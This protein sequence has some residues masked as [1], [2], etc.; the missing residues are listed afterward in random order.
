MLI[1]LHTRFA[2]NTYFIFVSIS[3]ELQKIAASSQGKLMGHDVS[4]LRKILDVFPRYRKSLIIGPDMTSFKSQ[5]DAIFVRNYLSEAAD[6]LDVFT[7]HP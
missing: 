2:V 5:N 4:R 1:K 6:S 7:W 3:L